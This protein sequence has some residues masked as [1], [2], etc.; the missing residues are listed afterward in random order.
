MTIK[1]SVPPPAI[2]V[3][4]GLPARTTITLYVNAHSYEPVEEVEVS[5]G[6]HGSS[7]GTSISRW[8]P[9][10]RRTVALARV[11]IPADYRRMTGP[12]TDFWNNAKPL[13]FIGY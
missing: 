2:L 5:P 4:A 8:L 10:T 13:F 11:R 9:T 1:L 3:R 6:G 7:A 12:V